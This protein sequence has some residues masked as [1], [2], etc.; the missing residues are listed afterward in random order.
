MAAHVSDHEAELAW[1]DFAHAVKVPAKQVMRIVTDV[2]EEPRHRGQALGHDV[3][4]HQAGKFHVTEL[5]RLVAEGLD[6]ADDLAA[7][8]AQGSR[9]D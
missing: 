7:G 1:G 6:A 5:T 2:E 3:P 9:S 8:V 4:L